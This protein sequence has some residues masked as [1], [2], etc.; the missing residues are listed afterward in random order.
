LFPVEFDCLF[1]ETSQKLVKIKNK[2][3]AD[4]TIA[5]ATIAHEMPPFFI[6]SPSISFELVTLKIQYTKREGAK[7]YIRKEVLE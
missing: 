5:I 4:N 3:K 2:M 1:S 7:K 6:F